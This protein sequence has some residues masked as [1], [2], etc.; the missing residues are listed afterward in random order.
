MSNGIYIGGTWLVNYGIHGHFEGS[1]IV[2]LSGIIEPKEILKTMEK[3]ILAYCLNDRARKIVEECGP[4]AI[5]SMNK[6][7]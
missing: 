2:T 6:L 3:H 7:A 5:R 4:I 1:A